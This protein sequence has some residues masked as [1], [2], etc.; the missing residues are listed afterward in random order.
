MITV[1]EFIEMLRMLPEEDKKLSIEYIDF[2]WK[3]KEHI[4]INKSK[5][6]SGCDMICIS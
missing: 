5:Y 6:P 3:E 4:L 2:S 1:N